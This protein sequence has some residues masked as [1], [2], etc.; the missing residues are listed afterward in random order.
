MSMKAVEYG[1]LLRL[2][3]RMRAVRIIT[4]SVVLL[5][6]RKPYCEGPSSELASAM[7]VIFSHI[8]TVTNLSKLEGMVMGLY[9]AVLRE[10]PPCKW[11]I[12]KCVGLIV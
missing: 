10:S 5:P 8:L 9:W 7:L 12:V 11:E 2:A 4:A 6:L 1:Q 3:F